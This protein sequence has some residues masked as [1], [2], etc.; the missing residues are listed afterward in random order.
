MR[1][2]VKEH[3][4]RELQFDEEDRLLS[5]IR[6]DYQPFVKF[7]LLSGWRV[8]EVRTLLWSDLDLPAP[9]A[10]RSAR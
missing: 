9:G 4:P 10:W 8:S 5:T 3:D 7:A 6:E 2:A 1:S